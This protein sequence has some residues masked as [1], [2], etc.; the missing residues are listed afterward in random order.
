MVKD[1]E[2]YDLLGVPTD[3]DDVKIKKAY[4]KMALKYHPDKNPGNKEAEQKF[5]EIAEAYQVLSV[6]QKRAI[7]DEVG[8]EE[9]NNSGAGAAEVDPK[10]FFTMMFGGEGFSDYIG[11]LNML[12]A[13]FDAAEKEATDEV[14]AETSEGA[15]TTGAGASTGSEST[16][17]GANAAGGSTTTGTGTTPDKAGASTGSS[18]ADAGP[19]LLEHPDHPHKHGKPTVVQAEEEKK[20]RDEEYAMLEKQREEQQQKVAELAEKLLAKIQPLLFSAEQSGGVFTNDAIIKF[21][22]NLEHEIESLKLESFGLNI[23]HTIVP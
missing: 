21:Q 19:S 1:T 9:L 8:K 23:C 7:Y 4:R 5:Q 3:A 20:K 13:M 2:Y 16:P 15:T 11:Q 10:E 18:S 12:N 6:P 22:T 17:T 14:N